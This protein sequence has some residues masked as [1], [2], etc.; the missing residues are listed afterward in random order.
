MTENKK[1]LR[2]TNTGKPMRSRGFLSRPGGV[3]QN[4][5]DDTGGHAGEKTMSRGKRQISATLDGR[6][7][8][9]SSK[10]KIK[11]YRLEDK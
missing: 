2:S 8:T 11:P 10:T 1:G 4:S 5:A 3:A 6:P 9:L 7:T